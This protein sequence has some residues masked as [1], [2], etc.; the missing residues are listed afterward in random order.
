MKIFEEEDFDREQFNENIDYLCK[1]D[2]SGM[3]FDRIAHI[4]LNGYKLNKT[5]YL[6]NEFFSKRIALRKTKN[7]WNNLNIRFDNIYLVSKKS[8]IK[9]IDRAIENN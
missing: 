2:S 7:L 8:D 5:I 3:I 1:L 4:L 9:R 6:P